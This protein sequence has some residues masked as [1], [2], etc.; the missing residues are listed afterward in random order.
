MCNESGG[1]SLSVPLYR[2]LYR[3]TRRHLLLPICCAAA[4]A[5]SCFTYLIIGPILSLP[6][7]PRRLLLLPSGGL[8]DYIVS[9]LVFVRLILYLVSIY[10]DEFLFRRRME[11]RII[12]KMYSGSNIC[13]RMGWNS[14]WT[15]LLIMLISAVFHR[16]L[17]LQLLL[18]L[19]HSNRKRLCIGFLYHPNHPSCTHQPA[20]ESKMCTR[21]N[22]GNYCLWVRITK[23]F[24]D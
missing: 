17:L 20:I 5:A 23:D 8:T 12:I 16:L 7:P 14:N 4:A 2:I 9:L 6:F 11:R 18:M 19:F 22:Y 3:P 13:I 10:K 24:R 15:L 1:V 21:E